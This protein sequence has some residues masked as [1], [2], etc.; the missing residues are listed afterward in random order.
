[1]CL[2]CKLNNKTYCKSCENIDIIN[3]IKLIITTPASDNY[4]NY[5]QIKDTELLH[6]TICDLKGTIG[7]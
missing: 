7:K 4:D 6:K 5:E 1:M 2:Y 3:L